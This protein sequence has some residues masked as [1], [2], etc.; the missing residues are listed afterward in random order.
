MVPKYMLRKLKRTLKK[1]PSNNLWDI[2]AAENI[3]VLEYELGT[4][5]GFYMYIQKTKVILLNHNLSDLQKKIVLSHEIGHA[6]LH[7]KVNCAF[8]KNNTQLKHATYETEANF[9]GAHLLQATGLLDEH[10]F[11]IEAREL[12]GKDKG[13]IEALMGLSYE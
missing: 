10:D 5:Y 6:V 2:A 12:S 13:F 1:S 4:M 3:L 11:A 8:I 7:S 9:F